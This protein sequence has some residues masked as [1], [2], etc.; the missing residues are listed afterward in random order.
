MKKLYSLFLVTLLLLTI[1]VKSQEKLLTIDD[2]VLGR[3]RGLSAKTLRQLQWKSASEFTY[4]DGNKLMIGNVKSAGEKELMNVI[5]FNQMLR[6]NNIDT[7]Q[8]FP[9]LEWLNE[10]NLSF[11]LDER[12]VVLN[13]TTGLTGINIRVEKDADN[14]TFWQPAKAI[15]YTK[16]NNLYVVDKDSKITQ[17][18]FDDDKDI[19]FGQKV[20]RDEFASTKGI[21]WSPLGNYLAFYRKDQRAVTNYPLVDITTRIATL[22]NDKYPMAGMKSEHLSLGVYN[23][24][25]GKT[26]YIEQDT[27]SE[28]YLTNI[29]WDPSE[30]Y[31]YIQVLNREQNHMLL[32]KYDVT[33]GAFVKTLF[34]EK[35]DKYVEPLHK[36]TFLKTQPSQFVYWSDRDGYRHLYLY[37]T[38]GQLIKQLTKGEWVVTELLGFDAKETNLFYNS[39][40]VSPIE[41]HAF[42]LE[43]KSGKITQLTTAAGWHYSTLNSNAEYI[44]DSYSSITVPFA[45]DLIDTKGKVFRNLLT[46]PNPLKDYKLANIEIFKIKAADGTTDLYARLI[47]PLNFDATKKYPAIVYVYGGPHEQLV[48]NTWLGAAGLWAF[49]MAQKGYVVFT[50]DNRGS[51]NRG[52]AFEQVIH[53]QLGVCEMADQIKGIEYLKKTGYV[54]T[55]LIGVHGWS[56]GGFMTTS[57][58]TTYPKVFKVGVAGG[59]VIDWKWY[60][61]MYGER[62]MDMPQENP[63][64]YEKISV[65]NKAKNLQGRLLIIHGD[66]DNTVVMQ[67]SLSFIKE[68]VSNGIPVDYFIYPQHEHNVS[69]KDRLHLMKK[70]TQ[71]FDD[72]LKK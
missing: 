28:K 30:K 67:H 62:Y 14:Q 38:D 58:M 44:L 41:N 9:F 22:K 50:V 19:V 17:I 3:T 63:E 20:S 42:K 70:I 57:L 25:N 61:V 13:T 60:E 29:T 39:S 72:F 5:A 15:A 64:G 56:Y 47:K 43:I 16:E 69:G 4:T 31:I 7:V 10:S 51:E 35:N 26:I 68:C 12:K 8:R 52:M 34:E 45:S 37:N 23:F 18:A 59:P 48:K 49:Y 2:A 54:D 65:L 46:S 33:T 40:A 55:T 11:D 66:I 21:F 1:N 24:A 32:N 36:L 27:A 71:Y 53:R 6:K